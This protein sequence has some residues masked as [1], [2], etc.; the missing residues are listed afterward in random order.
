MTKYSAHILIIKKLNK[1]L[2]F[3]IGLKIN[4]SI[5]ERF[6][7]NQ[8]ALRYI[9]RGLFDTDGSI[10][11]DKDKRYKT[12]YPIIDIRTA[13][14]ILIEQLATILKKDNFNVIKYKKGIRIKGHFQVQKWF[15]EIKPQNK[16]HILKYQNHI[17]QTQM[18]L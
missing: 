13:S 10:F 14:N 1:E 16:K 8:Y 5:S 2:G 9:I 7:K 11:F 3:P 12:P 17:T 15:K 18:G 4:L 6:L